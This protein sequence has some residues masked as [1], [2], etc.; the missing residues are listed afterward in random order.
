M[1]KEITDR[2]VTFSC[3]ECGRDEPCT[4]SI[5][6][7]KDEMEENGEDSDIVCP[8][9]FNSAHTAKLARIKK[10]DT[11]FHCTVP[12]EKCPK[13]SEEESCLECEYSPDYSESLYDDRS[14]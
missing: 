2:K 11:S 12:S 4:L 6:Y 8:W 9:Y 13:D 14:V 10:P 3:K 5:T 7:D 1:P